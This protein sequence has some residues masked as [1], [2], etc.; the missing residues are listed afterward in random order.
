M[1]L[2]ALLALS[3]LFGC[4]GPQRS[5]QLAPG[6]LTLADEVGVDEGAWLGLLCALESAGAFFASEHVHIPFIGLKAKQG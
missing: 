5:P 2:R 1:H 6:V 3:L 4:G